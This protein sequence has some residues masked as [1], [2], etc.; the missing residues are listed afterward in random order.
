MLSQI[1]Y[2]SIPSI[3]HQINH[4]S[5]F[6]III[7][8]LYPLNHLIERWIRVDDRLLSSIIY[9]K[10]QS[11]DN[12]IFIDLIDRHSFNKEELMVLI[13]H[14]SSFYQIRKSA[15]IIG[16]SCIILFGLICG[17][18]DSDE[19]KII[20]LLDVL[21]DLFKITKDDLFGSL[22]SQGFLSNAID[23]DR[24]ILVKF[25][26]DRLN[27]IKK[28]LIPASDRKSGLFRYS[29]WSLMNKDHS[30]VLM[31]LIDHY[32]IEIDYI[33][34]S[35]WSIFLDMIPRSSKTFDFFEEKYGDAFLKTLE[36]KDNQT[37]TY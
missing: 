9:L 34:D 28:D 7:K 37:M 19:D 29:I 30:S 26:I 17:K 20:T 16:R 18:N 13:K 21:I 5:D 4:L 31:F 36:M 22:P 10:E 33:M 1:P 11:S 25:L 3:L 32:D 6:R 12:H 2:Y 8:M 23:N 15:D 24:L 14:Y 35:R 27:I